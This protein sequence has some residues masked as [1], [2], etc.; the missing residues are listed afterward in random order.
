[1]WLPFYNLPLIKLFIL[2]QCHRASI[3]SFHTAD[4]VQLHQISLQVDP[5]KN[6]YLTGDELMEH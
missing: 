4:T 5:S 3:A 6:A 1:M 2:Y